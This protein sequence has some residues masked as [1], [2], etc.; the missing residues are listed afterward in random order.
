ME[1]CIKQ[2]SSSENATVY[3]DCC[4]RKTSSTCY[5]CLACHDF[6]YC[7]GCFQKANRIH[8]GHNFT[9]SGCSSSDSPSAETRSDP[10]CDEEFQKPTLEICSSCETLSVM[11]PSFSLAYEEVQ[12]DFRRKIEGA[13]TKDI[14]DDML[15][16]DPE[17]SDRIAEELYRYLDQSASSSMIDLEHMKKIPWDRICKAYEKKLGAGEDNRGDEDEEESD[18]TRL[19]IGLAEAMRDSLG[20]YA[21]VSSLEYGYEEEDKPRKHRHEDPSRN[22]AIIWKVRISKLVEA[23]QRGCV[24]CCF[25]LHKLFAPILLGRFVGYY[26]QFDTF[27][28]YTNPEKN[29]KER[30][31]L[32]A[33]AMVALTQLK[34]DRFE[35]AVLPVCSKKDAKF[36]DINQLHFK[37]QNAAD[38]HEVLGEVFKFRGNFHGPG[39]KPF[40]LM[41]FHVDVYTTRGQSSSIIHVLS[42]FNDDRRSRCPFDY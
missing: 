13:F 5:K 35:F 14:E 40:P 3:C 7:P 15:P 21:P 8:P 17:L 16:N 22:I 34:Y 39:E 11:L 38:D 4:C 36:P 20:S 6:D 28:W 27:T 31:R 29:A 26:G 9:L 37:L 42:S 32:V 41:R 25:F 19:G 10:E 12:E 1:D 18:S 33:D 2:S 23:T 24:F 30:Q